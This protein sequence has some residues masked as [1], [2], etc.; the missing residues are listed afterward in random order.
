MKVTAVRLIHLQGAMDH[1]EEFW[2]QR[3]LTYE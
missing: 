3:E 1:P 2:E